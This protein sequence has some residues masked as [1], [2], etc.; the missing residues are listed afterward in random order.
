MDPK[1]ETRGFKPRRS[2]DENY[3]RHVVDLL[4][5]GGRSVRDLAV[6][7]GINQTLL[8]DW[9]REFAPQPRADNGVP[10][11]PEEKDAEIRRLRAQL[12]RM[13]EREIILKKSLGILSETPESGLPKSKP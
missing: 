3:K 12:V 11:T 4:L 6:E 7:L 2:Y 5:Q 8:Y 10:Q 9:R 13:Q 1:K